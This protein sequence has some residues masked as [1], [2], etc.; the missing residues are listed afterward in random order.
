MFISKNSLYLIAALTVIATGVLG[1]Q[2][3]QYQQN[4][5]DIQIK[6]GKDGLSIKE[7]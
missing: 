4:T 6:I 2:Y 7:N 1:Y 5:T 3:Y